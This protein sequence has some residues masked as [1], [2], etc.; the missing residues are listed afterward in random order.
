[1]Q[2]AILAILF[3]ELESFQIFFYHFFGY[4]GPSATSHEDFNILN[5]G[6]ILLKFAIVFKICEYFCP[7]L[8][9]TIITGRRSFSSLADG[10]L[11][12]TPEKKT[13]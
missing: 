8:S 9:L 6:K 12:V 10:L 1:M 13:F 5:F 2:F 11:D 4:Q 3:I 7:F